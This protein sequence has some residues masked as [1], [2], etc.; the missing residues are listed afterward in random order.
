MQLVLEDLDLLLNYQRVLILGVIYNNPIMIGTD[1]AKKDQKFYPVNRDLLFRENQQTA[2]FAICDVAKGLSGTNRRLYRQNRVYRVKVDSVG[3]S[4]TFNP[5]D[6]Y[7]LK[8]SFMLQRGYAL[9]MEE[10][11]KSF[12]EAR[13]VTKEA[14]VGR[15]R[16]F[17]IDL[18]PYT[19][20]IEA[21][22]Q[23]L[24]NFGG[25]ALS[26]DVVIDEWSK[27]FS[28][29]TAGSSRD[30][31]L[32][33]DSNTFGIIHEYDKKGLVQ[34]SP[35]TASTE[36]AY[37]DLTADLDND[38]VFNLQVD[39]NQPP[40]DADSSSPTNFLR[41]VGT[42]YADPDNANKSS[43]GYF[44]APLG[45]VYIVGEGSTVPSIYRADSVNDRPELFSVTVQKGDY[46]GVAAHEY[47]EAKKLGA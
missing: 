42:I 33:E 9:A 2:G 25:K 22:P 19:T 47:V 8:D 11:N 41:Y 27:S 35:S 43:T 5:I 1:M 14:N 26:S 39:G 13:E 21:N 23:M 45:A 40:Y 7:V 15:W 24:R 20:D 16:D 18:R 17:R 37:V 29:T 6:V 34:S 30:F 31:A 28:W 46:K 38:E 44:D 3:A 36:A 10:W 32:F 4:K 12:D